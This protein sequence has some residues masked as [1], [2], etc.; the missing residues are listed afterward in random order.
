[1]RVKRLIED[2]M[3][4]AEWA[5]AF[6]KGQLENLT[7]RSMTQKIKI[8]HVMPVYSRAELSALIQQHDQLIINGIEQ[9][10]YQ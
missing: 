7:F 9:F 2:G 8:I 3:V 6:I 4:S 10:Y 1:M 5:D